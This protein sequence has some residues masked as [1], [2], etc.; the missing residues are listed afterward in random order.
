MNILVSGAALHTEEQ[1][2]AIEA[3]GHT[4]TVIE[5]ESD[6]LPL[7]CET[8]DAI[9]G[10]AMFLYHPIEQ[11]TRLRYIQ[12]LSAGLDRVPLDYVKSHGIAL[13]NARGVYSV[14]MAEFAIG[15][16]LQLY[17]ASRAFAAAQADGRWEKHRD[18]RELYGKTVCIVGCGSVGTECAKRFAAFGC[19]VIGVDLFPREDAAYAAML[20]LSQFCEVLPAADVVVLTLPLTEESRH[21]MDGARFDYIKH[22]AVLVNIARGAVVE[23]AALCEALD[24]G[25]LGGA[26]LDVF[27]E[28]PLDAASPLWHYDNVIATPH[29]SFVGDG[30]DT[31]MWQ[32]IYQNLTEYG[33]ESK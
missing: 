31:R 10:N 24:S 12:L 3:L 2:R 29:N 14:P 26:I 20:P 9:I 22:G 1:R 19:S 15:G 30:N 23:T 32:V 28:E 18:L 27:E 21:L 17:K 33:R 25:R 13:Y 7:P 6:A 11:F 16:V 8:V 5:R 4:V